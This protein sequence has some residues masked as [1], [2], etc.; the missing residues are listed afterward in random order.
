MKNQIDV[1][2]LKRRLD[3][4]DIIG[5]DVNL[6]RSGESFVGFCPMH[7]N[8]HTAALAVFPETQTWK[9]FGA[10]NDGG[11]VV[12]WVMKRHNLDFRAACEWL[13]AAPATAPRAVAVMAE[14][15]Y[16]PPTTEWQAHAKAFISQCEETLL[17]NGRAR[18]YLCQRGIDANTIRRYHIGLQPSDVFTDWG[19]GKLRLHCGITI[20]CFEG[21][22]LWY[23][24]VRRPRGEDPK[25]LN[26]R[27]GQSAA[28]FNASGLQRRVVVL[29]EGEFDAM[30]LARV[31]GPLVGVGTFGSQG[32]RMRLDCW[33]KYLMDAE[34][35]LV[36]Y[37]E[38]GKSEKGAANMVN[39]SAR[40][41]RIRPPESANG[42][43]IT[44]FW[45][46]NGDA[47]LG[48]WIAAEYEDAMLDLW[49][50]PVAHL[51][52]IRAMIDNPATPASLT[53]DY[54]ADE[55]EFEK[56]YA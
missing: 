38:D 2:E 47:A 39:L 27:G 51:A 12:A 50:D 31:A 54:R 15:P 32:N 3:I 7:K 17:R 44:D 35:I 53:A 9:C 49:P 13:G 16:A 45:Q 30:L 42:K 1:E 19:D 22:S 40:C 43:D 14:S 34:L 20:P 5:R 55:Q 21:E 56:F 36:C 37:D 29:C 6:R 23:V 26:I 41:R 48:H 24:K 33:A 10:C 8:T 18:D 25:Y 52:H 11:D 4:V 28:L 46:A